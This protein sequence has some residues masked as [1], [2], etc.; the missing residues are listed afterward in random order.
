M[1]DLE[2]HSF[3]GQFATF[4]DVKGTR[5]MLDAIEKVW[6]SGDRVRDGLYI[7][8]LQIDKGTI[9]YV[10]DHPGNGAVPMVGGGLQHQSGHR[11]K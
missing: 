1:E 5:A 6:E 9:G 8:N 11:Q 3:A 2:N 7:K 10:R 4:L